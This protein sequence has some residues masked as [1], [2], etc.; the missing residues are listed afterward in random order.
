MHIKNR[1]D[2]L[3]SLS[4]QLESVSIDILEAQEFLLRTDLKVRSR[5]EWA[6]KSQELHAFRVRILEEI[7]GLI[8]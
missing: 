2:N 5:I 4:R 8:N 7:E 1:I 3:R 6:Q